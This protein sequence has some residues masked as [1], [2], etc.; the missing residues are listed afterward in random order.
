[1]CVMGSLSR[2]FGRPRPESEGY[3][4]KSKCPTLLRTLQNEVAS[5]DLPRVEFAF[6]YSLLGG[7]TAQRRPRRG[8]PLPRLL[9]RRSQ[10]GQVAHLAA[11]PGFRLAVEVEL[12][13]GEA[14]G[15]GP[16]PPR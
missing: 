15:R 3:G 5:R 11:G 10:G 14:A 8:H 1:M 7:G 12:D 4:W 6:V 13:V 2:Q 9:H 16:G